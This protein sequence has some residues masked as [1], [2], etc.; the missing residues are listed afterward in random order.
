MRMLHRPSLANCV[1]LWGMWTGRVR[2]VTGD[3]PFPINEDDTANVGDERVGHTTG[4]RWL[5]DHLSVAWPALQSVHGCFEMVVE[6]ELARGRPYDWV[7][8]A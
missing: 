1:F 4:R 7:V 5:Q 3:P 8:S 6:E 2:I